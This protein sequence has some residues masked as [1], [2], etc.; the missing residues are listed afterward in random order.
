MPSRQKDQ[1]DVSGYGPLPR[2]RGLFFTGTDT[3][4]GKTLVA[5]AA[6]AALVRQGLRVEVLKPVATGCRRVSGNLVSGDAEFLAAMADSRRSLD[7]IAPVRYAAALAPTVAAER[8]RRPVE[9][10]AIFESYRRLQGQCDAVIVEG[11]GGL[12]CPLTESFWVIHLAKLMGLPLVVVARAGLGTI[13]H[14][15]LTLHAARTAGLRVAGVV[16]NG[17]RIDS[18][19]ASA[20]SSGEPYTRGDGEIA[21]FH[22]PQQIA[23]L[24]HAPVLALVPQEAANSVEGISVGP[25]T[26]YAISQVDW[27]ELMDEV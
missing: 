2:L 16:V 6:A 11:I 24:G 23:A 27:Q 9:L 7:E 10:D 19:A 15:L 3:E 5:G 25:D 21:M 26:E 1:F 12:M 20:I 14:T 17:Y 4:V 18:T 8:S 22:N 13:N